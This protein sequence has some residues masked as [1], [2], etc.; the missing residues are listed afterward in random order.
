[1]SSQI[2]SL[3]LKISKILS[4]RKSL[5]KKKFESLI[6]GNCENGKNVLFTSDL[7]FYKKIIWKS[8]YPYDPLHY[9]CHCLRLYPK[10]Y[11][12]IFNSWKGEYFKRIMH[13]WKIS[14]KAITLKIAES[15]WIS[16]EEKTTLTLVGRWTVVPEM[17]EQTSKGITDILKYFCVVN[18]Q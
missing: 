7:S 16:I 17:T 18:F 9:N 11:F 15:L 3:L 2:S 6:E 1:M 10:K 12:E 4:S 14:L 5:L 13:W 8:S